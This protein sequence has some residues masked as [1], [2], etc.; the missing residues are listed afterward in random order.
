MS[1]DGVWT[2]FSEIKRQKSIKSGD[3]PEIHVSNGICTNV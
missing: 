1:F 3:V 2:M